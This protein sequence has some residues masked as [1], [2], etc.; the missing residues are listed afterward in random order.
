MQQ[1]ISVPMK[2][3]VSRPHVIMERLYRV[4]Q[5]ILNIEEQLGNLIL[6]EIFTNNPDSNN[7]LFE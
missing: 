7:L 1:K 6:G 3:L 5:S 4:K 2:S